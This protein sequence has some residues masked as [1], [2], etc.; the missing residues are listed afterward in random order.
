MTYFFAYGSLMDLDFVTSLGVQYKSAC[1]GV[2]MGY[3]FKINVQDK[4][5]P[6]FGYANIV[7]NINTSVEGVLMEITQM[8]FPLLDSYEGYPQMYSR[9]KMQIISKNMNKIHTAWVYTGNL[10][11]IIA[12][13][14]C[15][16]PFQ[17]KRINNGFR[18]LSK[19][20]QINLLRII[21]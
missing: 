8:E 7:K 18:F 19:E 9:S 12:R 14:L 15:L 13:N 3:E 17:K 16:T 5:N 4:S 6:R 20:Y 2:L 1:S 21:K 11:F 10:N